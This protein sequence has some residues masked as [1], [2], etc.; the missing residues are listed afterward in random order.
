MQ[1]NPN[2]N[3]RQRNSAPQNHM[4]NNMNNHDQKDRNQNPK[5][6]KNENIITAV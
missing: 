6:I 4:Y 5:K 3:M 2:N 1:D